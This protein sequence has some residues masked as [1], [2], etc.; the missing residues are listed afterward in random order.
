MPA[1]E[2]DN[3]S[4]STVQSCRDM[5]PRD[6]YTLLGYSRD[7]DWRP[8]RFVDPVP[9]VRVCSLCGLIP[10]ATVQ[11]PCT[12][13]LCRPCYDGCLRQGGVCALDEQGFTS[14]D[15]EWISLSLDNFMRR[16]V[17]CW[18]DVNGCDVVVEVSKI[19]DHFSN[20]CDFH[21]TSCSKCASTVLHRDVIEHLKSGCLTAF[22]P[23]PPVPPGDES[24][25][26]RMKQNA[27]TRKA[28]IEAV[29][30][31][32]DTKAQKT[33]LEA[34][35][36]ELKE[37]LSQSFAALATMERSSSDSGSEAGDTSRKRHNSKQ[38]DPNGSCEAK[39]LREG[40]AEV[41]RAWKDYQIRYMTQ[42]ANEASE[43]SQSPSKNRHEWFAM[44]YA[45]LK[46]VALR[47]GKADAPS[48]PGYFFGYRIEPIIRFKT[49]GK[50]VRMHFGL[51]VLRGEHDEQ[52]L[53]PFHHNVRLW[54]MV[55]SGQA[56]GGCPLEINAEAVG[57]RFYARPADGAR[58]NGPCF[59]SSSV[60][61][62][63]LESG[64]FVEN[65]RLRLRFEVLP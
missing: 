52:L 62:K 60:D 3:G 14:E 24:P 55:P 35:L 65:D 32:E 41:L 43:K 36:K 54:M 63:A 64:G 34:S 59:S 28:L 25:R 10:E 18:N 4:V 16:K 53:W 21:A 20:E 48:S 49:H 33:S 11:L 47:D 56:S 61:L 23:G 7:L 22:V 45:S 8:T 12:H 46:E 37:L 31:L 42:R 5:A 17:H 2:D 13:I 50:N 29:A 30:A 39:H 1:E 26:E 6:T 15:A 40:I 57:E 27:E 51:Q 58:G 9:S 38:R 44:S 19:A